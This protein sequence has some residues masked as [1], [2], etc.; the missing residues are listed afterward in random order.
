MRTYDSTRRNSILDTYAALLLN[1]TSPRTPHSVETKMPSLTPSSPLLPFSLSP[2]SLFLSLSFLLY[3]RQY[4]HTMLLTEISFLPP[5]AC[6]SPSLGTRR[7]LVLDW[8]RVWLGAELGKGSAGCS[9]TAATGPL[10]TW[11]PEVSTL[12]RAIYVRLGLNSWLPI[13]SVWLQSV[14][15]QGT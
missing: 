7:T 13:M 2:F 4:Q 5:R 10:G 8:I 14:L 1:P 6:P 11:K 12:L 9:S 3:F 15:S